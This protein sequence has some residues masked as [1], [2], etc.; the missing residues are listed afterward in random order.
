MQMT[1]PS[2]CGC[3]LALLGLAWLTLVV[4]GSVYL[5]VHGGTAGL[6]LEAPPT[7]PSHSP[8][9]HEAGVAQVTMF[10]HP[11]C[12]CTLASLRQFERAMAHGKGRVRACVVV[13]DTAD[14]GPRWAQ[15]PVVEKAQR[16][17]DVQVI[18]DREGMEA[19]RFGAMTSGHVVLYSASGRLAFSGGLTPARGH[20]GPCGGLQS[21]IAGLRGETRAVSRA[22]VFGC[23]IMNPNPQ[24]VCPNGEPPC[25]CKSG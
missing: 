10:I 23:A 1:L 3:R 24:A 22:A 21:L 13:F 15:T 18:L 7:W 17:A 6:Q 2:R 12:P 5:M 25:P 16:L 9:P 20:E 11:G 14:G 4:T 8:I 19:R